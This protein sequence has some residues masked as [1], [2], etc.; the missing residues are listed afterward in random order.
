MKRIKTH[1]FN[2]KEHDIDLEMT[3]GYC[4]SPR[5]GR[6]TLYVP[7]DT[8]GEFKTLR[9]LIHEAMHACNWDKHE[10]TVDVCSRDITR[11]LWRL[12]YRKVD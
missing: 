5:G 12:G 6:P 9:I 7:L 11:F 2:G 10:N 1:T 8:Y 3:L 4:D